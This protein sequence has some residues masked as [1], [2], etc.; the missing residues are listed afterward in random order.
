MLLASVCDVFDYDTL[1]HCYFT[2]YF[3]FHYNLKLT[4]TP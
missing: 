2:T 4:I 1:L 3:K